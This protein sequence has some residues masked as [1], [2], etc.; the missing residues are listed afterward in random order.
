MKDQQLNKNRKPEWVISKEKQLEKNLPRRVWLYGIHAVRDAIENQN[1]VKHKLMLT[2]NAH[3][4]IRDFLTTSSLFPFSPGH[5]NDG[6]NVFNAFIM[7][8]L[9]CVP[10][11]YIALKKEQENCFKFLKLV[12]SLL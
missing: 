4:K 5:F 6:L 1:R 3:K 2:E 8:T 7:T 12:I 11:D 9:I 10:P